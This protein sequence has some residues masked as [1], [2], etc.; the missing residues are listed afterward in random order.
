VAQ[1]RPPAAARSIA[2]DRDGQRIAIGMKDGM[3]GQHSWTNDMWTAL[4]KPTMPTRRK[5]LASPTRET[6]AALC[7]SAQAVEEPIEPSY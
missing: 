6:A 3:L 2:L 4:G 7:H 1:I 5:S